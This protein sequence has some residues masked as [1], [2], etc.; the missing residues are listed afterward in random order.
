MGKTVLAQYTLEDWAFNLAPILLIIGLVVLVY[1]LFLRVTAR[2]GVAVDTVG[3][4]HP[5]NFKRLAWRYSFRPLRSVP[6]ALRHDAVT[7]ADVGGIN[8]V[9]DELAELRDFLKSP[10]RFDDI[11]A[12]VPKGV[13]MYGPPGTGK[14]LMAKAVATEA[15]VPFFSVSG[16][17]FTQ[18]WVGVGAARA[19]HLFKLARKHAP[20]IVF[21]DEID[22]AGAHRSDQDGGTREDNRTLNAILKEMDGFAV[23]KHPVIVIGATNRLDAL[24]PALLRP[25]RFDRHIAV[26]AP[27]R[28]GRVE[29]V[30]LHARGKRL[31]P[32]VTPD[33][34]ARLTPGFV[35]ADLANLLNEAA[36]HA[37]RE[38]RTEIEQ[39]HVEEALKRL[40]AGAA[41]S[42]RYSDRHR[43]VVAFHE[44]GHALLC[45]RLT[46]EAL[47]S[48]SITRRGRSGGQTFTA[49][50]DNP[51]PTKQETFDVVCI[52][53]GGRAAELLAF[54]DVTTGAGS[55]LQ[56]ASTLVMDMVSRH[57]MGS[58]LG[59]FSAAPKDTSDATYRS[60]EMEASGLL[61]E[62]DKRAQELLS[63]A[64]TT[65]QLVADA[66]LE[67]ETIDRA[68]FEE[69]V[70]PPLFRETGAPHEA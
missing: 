43:R 65:L 32:D 40:V 11:G 47:Q 62:Q 42:G 49:P 12:R 4:D 57:G 28:D 8:E 15:G 18:K 2:Q 14:T 6:V 33:W 31:A 23:S 21:I 17:G 61:A 67:E 60:L 9:V 41:K 45:W 25:G 50:E 16:S 5:P 27:D 55:D 19:R 34:V 35:G 30:A 1:W 66:L 36:I 22:S 54:G 29:I 63:G 24:D 68:R 52:L 59:L 69:I 13:L 53:L 51:L 20:A 38:E 44:A 58:T 46:P 10:Q 37:V 7:F 39:H 64:G 56:R 3:V 48:V 26:D 70:G